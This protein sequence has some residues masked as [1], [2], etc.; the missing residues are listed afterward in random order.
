MKQE[1]KYR[2]REISHWGRD[3][4]I[5]R[6]RKK[7]RE[8]EW[9][10]DRNKDVEGETKRYVERERDKEICR[11]GDLT[12]FNVTGKEKEKEKKN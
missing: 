9:E 4:K 6:E 12:S 1:K 5:R 10:E 3:K 11:D 8:W 7:H 2:K